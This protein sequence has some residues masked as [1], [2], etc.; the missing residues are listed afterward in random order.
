M[1]QPFPFCSGMQW[2]SSK[3][4]PQNNQ[5]TNWGTWGDLF[6]WWL[7]SLLINGGSWPLF[8][9]SEHLEKSMYIIKSRHSQCCYIAFPFLPIQGFALKHCMFFPAHQT[10]QFLLPPFSFSPVFH[11]NEL[12]LEF[13]CIIL[14]QHVFWYLERNDRSCKQLHHAEHLME[15]TGM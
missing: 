3:A 9:S 5:E 15:P 7:S 1:F 6:N 14:L 8:Q 12:L 10:G 2:H 4:A 11:T 13:R